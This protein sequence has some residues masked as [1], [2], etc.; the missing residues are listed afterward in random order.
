MSD[1]TPV[2]SLSSQESD[3]EYQRRL[4][5]EA[6]RQ[7]RLNENDSDREA[8]RKQ[9]TSAHRLSRSLLS[10]DL[11][12]EIRQEN[13][14]TRA[15]SRSMLSDTRRAEILQKDRHA[16]HNQKVAHLPNHAND[17]W[18][19]R[20]AILNTSQTPTSLG[21]RW[22]RCCKTCGIKVGDFTNLGVS[23]SLDMCR[24]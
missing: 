18:W 11:A 19:D 7:R 10:D 5:R 4:R 2:Y 9:N 3:D 24:P 16:Y 13:S 17:R 21:L 15:L 14:R 20:V 23:L 22:N 8:R 1:V 12:L 6:Q